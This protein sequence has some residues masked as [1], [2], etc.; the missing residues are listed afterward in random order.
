M[1]R[2]C[3]RVDAVEGEAR[4]IRRRLQVERRQL[5]LLLL[6]IGEM[7]EGGGEAVGEE[8]AWSGGY[9]LISTY[10]ARFTPL[11]SSVA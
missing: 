6:V 5:R 7:G 1:R 2:F 3:E 10:L 9:R 11:R 4:R 8:G